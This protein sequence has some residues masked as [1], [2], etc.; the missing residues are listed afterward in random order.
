ME[1]KDK[2]A[3]TKKQAVTKENFLA[4]YGKAH[5]CAL[6]ELTIKAAFRK[7]GLWPFNRD[8]IT[9]AMMAPSLE[10]SVR[11]HLPIAPST[12]VRVM[13]DLLY[14]VSRTQGRKQ[15]MMTH[16]NPPHCKVRTHHLHDVVVYPP[17]L[18]THLRPQSDVPSSVCR[19]LVRAS[20][21]DL[22]TLLV[23]NTITRLIFVDSRDV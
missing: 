18:L 21:R 4:I 8:V 12:P 14:Q 1:E 16:L 20:D 3:R 9:P 10:M 19:R 22:P 23:G 15:I 11:G 7:T 6:T 17:R 5:K 2:W 13:T